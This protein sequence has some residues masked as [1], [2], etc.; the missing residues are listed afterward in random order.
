MKPMSDRLRRCVEQEARANVPAARAKQRNWNAVAAALGV[1]PG[2]PPPGGEGGAAPAVSGSAAGAKA[3]P[4]VLKWIAGVAVATGVAVTA[5]VAD[6]PEDSSQRVDAPAEVAV[7]IDERP[8]GPTPVAELPSAP[9]VALPEV[10]EP[11]PPPTV[12]PRPRSGPRS[13]PKPAPQPGLAQEVALVEQARRALESGDVSRALS[14]TREH[15]R[16]FSDGELVPDRLNLEAA[17]LCE[18]GRV[19]QGRA[20]LERLRRDWPRAPVTKRALRSCEE[21]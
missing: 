21:T 7:A 17:A 14:L 2:G 16:R 10:D 4:G 12:E 20:L 13:R 6:G 3:A 8:T 11:E 18:S 19:E 15:A 9:E 5:V 1:P